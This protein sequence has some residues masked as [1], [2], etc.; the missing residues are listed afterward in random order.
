MSELNKQALIEQLQLQPHVEGGYFRRSYCASHTVQT[1]GLQLRPLASAIYYLLTDDSPIGFF[2]RNQSDILHLWQ[3][4]SPLRYVLIDRQGNIA[5]HIL[6]PN[7][8][9]GEHL[10]LLVPGGHWKATELVEGQFGLLSEVVCPGFE[11]ADMQLASA[12]Q[13]QRDFPALWADPQLALEKYCKS[14]V[15]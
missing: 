3:G 5:S 12:G 10:Q 7:L 9:A 8:A 1:T 4:G 6:G 15:K 11:Y 2:H 14:V 13:M